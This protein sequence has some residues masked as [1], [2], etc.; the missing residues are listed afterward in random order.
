MAAHLKYKS[1]NSWIDYNLVVYPV[2]AIYLG[3]SSMSPANLFGGTWTPITGRFLYCNAGTGTGGNNSHTHSLSSGAAMIDIMAVANQRM[4]IGKTNATQRW[5]YSGIGQPEG[6]RYVT[7]SA[8]VGSD[9][10][11]GGY[12]TKLT[13][14][15]GSSSNMPAYQTVYAWRRTA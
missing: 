9:S 11:N 10:F 15:S 1:G 13:G 2:G 6:S 3:F 12:L 14:N 4:T 5:G 7:G 8:G